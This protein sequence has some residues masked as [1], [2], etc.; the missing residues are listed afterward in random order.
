MSVRTKTS[1][2]K[3]GRPALKP[4]QRK[5][6]NVT[7]RLRD[8]LKSDLQMLAK[9]EGR[10]LSEEIEFRV[11]TSVLFDN[12]RYADFHDEDTYRFCLLLAQ[13][14]RTIVG[15]FGGH[16]KDDPGWFAFVSGA[17]AEL[18]KYRSGKAIDPE[19]R[20]GTEKF[21]ALVGGG[22]A[23]TPPIKSCGTSAPKPI[24]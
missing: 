14:A 11:E 8:Q 17:W 22:H 21:A 18:V 13:V 23:T 7:I 5:R 20:D 9:A 6:N 3:R 10:S 19:T 16:W 4:R 12:V 24:G 1:T 15:S 2:K